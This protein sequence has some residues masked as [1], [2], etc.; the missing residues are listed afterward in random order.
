[1]NDLS[2]LLDLT[3]LTSRLGRGA[4]TGV[5]RVEAAYLRALIT[6]KAPFWALVRSN[7][8]Y[9]LLDRDG[10]A[11]L[12]TL[13]DKLPIHADLLSRL[14]CRGDPLRAR[15][16][17]ALRRDAVARCLPFG[18]ARM[19]RQRLPA[20]FNYLNTGHANLSDACM[21]AVRAGGAAKIAVLL[22]D[23]IPLDYPEFTRPGI[24]AVFARKLGVIARHADLVIH[25]AQVTRIANEAQLS[26]IARP[27]QGIVAHLGVETPILA[28][29]PARAHP[30]FVTLGTI[31]PRKNHALLLDVWEKLHATQSPTDIPHLL[32]LGA[33]GWS[34]QTVFDRLDSLPF[35]GKT[36]FEYAN[37]PDEQVASLI[38]GAQ[39]L[40]F[41]SLVEGY[42]LPPLEAASLGTTVILPQLPIYQETMGDYPV[43]VRD[44][45]SYSWVETILA[46]LEGRGTGAEAEI[47]AGRGKSV[48]KWETIQPRWAAHFNIVLSIV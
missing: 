29:G 9:L 26:R 15:A 40:L 34:N 4:W 23:T 38:S 2:R 43:Y 13:G 11:K 30:Y 44:F 7:A 18:L 22:H 35:M 37:L 17:T 41:P 25:S 3:R 33:R 47:R 8:G 31:E 19:L 27:P 48:S 28:A 6:Q 24:A 45:D 42:G 14:T 21:N 32:I 16:E 12:L 39:G 46:V 1:M 36:V 20:G 10:A 5:D